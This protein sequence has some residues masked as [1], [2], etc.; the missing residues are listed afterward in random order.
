MEE[1]YKEKLR[2]G[3]A[4][5]KG[6]MDKKFG[7]FYKSIRE[8]GPVQGTC[9]TYKP[10]EIIKDMEGIRKDPSSSL[11]DPNG[12]YRGVPRAF[13]YRAKFT[14]LVKAEAEAAEKKMFQELQKVVESRA[15]ESETLEKKGMFEFLKR[16]K[17]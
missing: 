13:G 2:E 4:D 12:E 15:K 9:G 17:R 14:E 11:K 5:I 1:E 3:Y 16:K 6:G 8:K 7:E 10:K